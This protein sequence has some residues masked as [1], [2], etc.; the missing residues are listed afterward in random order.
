MAHLAIYGNGYLAKYR[1]AGE[2]VQLGLLHPERIRPELER[3]ACASAT[4]RRPAPNYLE[5][6]ELA[7][8]VETDLRLTIN[9][10]LE[11]L[12]LDGVA[13]SGNQAPSTD[14]ILVS[15]R[16]AITTIQGNGYTP[17]TL[18][19]TPAASET[20]DTMVGGISGGTADFVFGAGKFA[21]GTMFG[22]N[23]VISKS[24][25]APVVLDSTANGRLYVSPISLARFEVDA[26]STNRS[27][28]R[29]EGSGAYGVER[30]AAAV[31]IAAS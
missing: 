6:D 28:I 16:K 7:T 12:V 11:R 24:V 8:V 13:T 31:R 1:Q 17:D 4:R 26:G 27:N 23:V 15:V 22:L 19:L 3:G 14:N 20:V 9:E 18:V 10:G 30:T 25:P 2:I 5:R 29:M 21:P